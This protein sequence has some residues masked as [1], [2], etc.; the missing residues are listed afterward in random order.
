[1]K[2][3]DQYFIQYIQPATVLTREHVT[4]EVITAYEG[5]VQAAAT[6]Y[7]RPPELIDQAYVGP[8]V[9]L[10]IANCCFDYA[11]EGKLD[12]V[13]FGMQDESWIDFARFVMQARWNAEFYG[14]N[15]LALGLEHLFCLG[16]IRARLDSDTLANTADRALPACLQDQGRGYLNLFEIAV[17]AQMVEKSVRNATQPNAP[18]RLFTRKEGTR[19]VVDSSE[20]LRWLQGRRNFKPTRLV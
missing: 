9:I 20:A 8:A 2:T 6:Q 7:R 18:D 15:S 13:H 16:S 1:M 3:I 19:T 5:D 14:G 12:T 11:V 10:E 4:A 17:L